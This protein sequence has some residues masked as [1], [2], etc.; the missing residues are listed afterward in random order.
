MP[1]PHRTVQSMVAVARKKAA[2][3]RHPAPASGSHSIETQ[4]FGLTRAAS[5]F[6]H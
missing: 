6:T 5:F 3:A 2:Y 4:L 1:I